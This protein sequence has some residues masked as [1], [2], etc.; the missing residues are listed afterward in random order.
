MGSGDGYADS[1][2]VQRKLALSNGTTIMA[3]VAVSCPLL[4]PYD[5]QLVDEWCP[6]FAS[7]CT[8]GGLLQ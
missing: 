2:V 7:V 3:T 1:K 4:L 5:Q 6:R 8:A